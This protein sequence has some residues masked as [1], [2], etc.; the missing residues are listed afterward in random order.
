MHKTTILSEFQ[1]SGVA[2]KPSPR[3]LQ[4]KHKHTYK[5]HK[6]CQFGQFIFGKIFKIVA[7]RSHLLKLK[8]IKFNFGWGSTPDPTGG[9][10]SIPPDPLA[11]FQG[12]LL[13]REG[14]GEEKGRVGSE[15]KG[16]GSEG[17]KGERE[18]EERETS[19]PLKFLATPLL[20]IISLLAAKTNT[21]M[22]MHVKPRTK[23][24]PAA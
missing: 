15:R 12:I 19:P 11:G 18:G 9:A 7:T 16:A 1:I 8:C 20:Q 24:K 4:T 23:T 3:I 6:I 5:L 10:H 17:T 14:R 22:W 21:W 13:L 2:R